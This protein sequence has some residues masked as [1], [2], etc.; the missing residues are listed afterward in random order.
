MGAV[1]VRIR[2]DDDLVITELGNIEIVVDAGPEG[3]DH[4]FDLRVAVDPVQTGFFHVEDL[5]AERKDGLRRTVAG[6]LGAA[7]GRIALHDVDLAVFR[8]FVGAVRKLAGQRHAVQR[9]FTPGQLSGLAGGLPGSLGQDGFFHDGFCHGGIFFKVDLQLLAHHVVHGRTGFGIAEL[10][11]G[12]GFKL[13]IFDLDADDGGQAFTDVFAGKVRLAVLQQ[14]VFARVVVKGLGDGVPEAHHVGAALGG[15]DVVDKAVA[16][17]LIGIVV[18]HGHFH[19]DAVL[20]AFAE[21][22]LWIEGL[23]APV[24][25][26]DKLHDAA[27]VAEGPLLLPVLPLVLQMDLEAFGEEGHLS[28]ALFKD[29]VVKIHVL[30]HFAVREERHLCA[31]LFRI[32]FADDLEL[33]DGLSS[34]ISLAV[35]LPFVE[36]RDLQP[37][38]QGVDDRSAYAVQAAGYLVSPAAELAAGVEHSKDDLHGGQA[39]FM[40]DAHGNAAAVVDNGHGIILVDDHLNV[41]ADASQRLVHGIVYD[42]IYKMMQPFYGSAADI[43]AGSFADGLQP[44]QDLDLIRAVFHHF[45]VVHIFFHMDSPEVF[46]RNFPFLIIT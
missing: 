9:R 43:H 37:L 35:D 32:A 18:L 11:L 44:F 36:D 19:R 38:G 4:G 25:V 1:H 40:V 23:L 7:A 26:L 13:G 34:L 3:G 15:V 39:R 16:V 41:R 20:F 33:V 12:L 27:A 2:H 30:E 5:S 45:V 24:E 28:Q 31:G 42:F 14:F 10:D 22:D 17:F 6:A 29:V 21:D 46:V 8:V